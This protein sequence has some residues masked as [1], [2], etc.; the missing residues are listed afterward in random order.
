MESSQVALFHETPEEATAADIAALGGPKKV[1]GWLFPHLNPDQ[2]A[3]QVR[4]CLNTD[5]PEKL[6]QGQVLL[7]KQKAR[8]VGSD[9]LKR[10]EDQFLGCRTEWI[11][12]A[13]E[14]DELRR[15]VRDLLKVMN[16]RLERIE[17]IESRPT[18][19]AVKR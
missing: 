15:D 13:N 1:G 14:A 9:A 4:A 11:D 2:A 19:Q 3:A 10:Y 7:I 17:R 16:Q 5:R 12:P 6:G 18:L 8:E